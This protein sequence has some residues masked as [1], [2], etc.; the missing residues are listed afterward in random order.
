MGYIKN[1]RLYSYVDKFKNT[2]V[3]VIG[4]IMLDRFLYG[5]VERISPEAPVPIFKLKSE[6]L[7]LGGAGNVAANLASLGCKP[8]FLGFVGLDINGKR[9]TSLLKKAGSHSHL[10]QLTNY[11]TIIKTRF[12]ANHNHLL[13]ADEED[14][15]PFIPELLPK[16]NK[17][18]K[19]AIKM[20]DIV[21][22]SDYNKGIFNQETT[23]MIINLC[24]QY[25]VPVIVDP[26]GN[27]YSKYRGATLIKPNVKEFFEATGI[28]LDPENSNFDKELKRGAKI[29]SQK[30]SINNIIVTLS[31]YGMAYISCENKYQFVKIPTEAKEVCDVS[32]AGDT[33][34]ATLG[35]ALGGKIPL[36]DAMQLANIASGIVVGKLGTATVSFEELKQKLS[37]KSNLNQHIKN[38]KCVELSDAKQIIHNL[39]E[40]G[41]KIGFTNGCF[42]LMHLGHLNSLMQA[43]NE[44]DIL[45]VGINSD[46]SVKKKKGSDR[47]IQDQNTRSMLLS[48]LEFIDYVIVFDEDNANSLIDELRPDVLAKEGYQINDWPE[49]QRVLGYG[50]K[51]IQLDRIEGYSTSQIIAKCKKTN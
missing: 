20:T 9:V 18:A 36:I 5:T 4:D 39:K 34:L 13:R 23:Q 50:G 21:L 46:E 33:S 42:D 1:N 6:K 19:Q 8:T 26:K 51:V 11:P 15:L 37:T 7:M 27:D 35:I 22:L 44:C 12:I 10:Y 16:F 40:Q 3:T 24:K 28:K 48:S 25:K 29:F 14:I 2:K 41:K 31:E 38:N 30:Y 17:L 32:G 49:A 47:P 43:K 45:V